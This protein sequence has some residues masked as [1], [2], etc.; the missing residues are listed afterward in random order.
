MK[1]VTAVLALSL[2]LICLP[3]SV[4]AVELPGP[5]V[6][7][8]WL[9]DNLDQVVVLDVRKDVKS[10]TGQ[11]RLKKDKKS[12][13]LTIVAVG[14]HIPGAGLVNYKKVRANRSIDG[15]RIHFWP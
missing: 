6:E 3:A 5:L 2:A 7:P 8:A 4:P 1:P 12:G 13:K 14:G 15:V 9:E 10:F 11:A